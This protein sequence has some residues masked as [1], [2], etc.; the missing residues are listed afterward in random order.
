MVRSGTKPT[1]T[2]AINYPSKVVDYIEIQPPGTIKTSE[3]LDCEIRILGAG[4]TVGNSEGFDF[5]PTEAQISYDGGTYSRIFYGTNLDVNPDTVVW[6]RKTSRKT[7][8]CALAENT[9]TMIHGGLT[10]IHPVR[11]QMSERWFPVVSRHQMCL[12]IMPQASRAFCAR[13]SMPEAESISAP[14]MS[15]YSWSLLT[16]TK[17]TVDTTSKT[18]CSS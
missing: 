18:W 2:W 12:N 3:K 1:L 9:T 6:S 10:S 16:L 17:P 8:C 5:V 13:I 14:W 11:H 4:V 7:S 15:L